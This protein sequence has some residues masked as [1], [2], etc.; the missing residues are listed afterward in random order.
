MTLSPPYILDLI[1]LLLQ[2]DL[3]QYAAYKAFW[4]QHMLIVVQLAMLLSGP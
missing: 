4:D 3:H 2:T 1:L